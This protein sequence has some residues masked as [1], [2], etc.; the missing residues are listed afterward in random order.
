MKRKFGFE[1]F[2]IYQ[3]AI[4][5]TKKI[6]NQVKTF[7]DFEQYGLSNQL[8][9]STLSILNNIAEG[10]GRYHHRM[11]VQFYNFSRSSS[12]ECVPLLTIAFQQGY[13]NEEK[14]EELYEDCFEISIMISGLIKSINNRKSQ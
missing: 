11:K 3:R 5:F 6:Y 1:N 12:H 14:F 9:R 2:E 7:P 8:R 10:Y 13:I 4:I